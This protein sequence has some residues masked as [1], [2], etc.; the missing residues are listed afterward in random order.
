M[1]TV[2]LKAGDT[3]PEFETDLSEDIGDDEPDPRL[4]DASSVRFYMD[5]PPES[6]GGERPLIINKTV[7]D[8][9]E[10]Q[11]EVTYDFASGETSRS[12]EHHAEI[13]VTY[14]D[15]EVRTFPNEDQ[16]YIVDINEPVNRDVP[17]E[18]PL[19]D[20]DVSVATVD[21][22]EFHLTQYATAAD[23]PAGSAPGIIGITP[24]GNLLIEDGS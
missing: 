4:E 10:G 6:D 22:E 23:A 21:A 5:A 1:P 14:T 13:V 3:T 19:N 9:S 17:P 2:T 7:T 18:A 15:G 24:D 8:Y 20:V 11:G 12:G 16:Y